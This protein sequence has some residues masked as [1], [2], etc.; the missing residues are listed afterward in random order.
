M[1][2][3]LVAYCSSS[4]R[5]LS[6]ISA[7]SHVVFSV[8]DVLKRLAGIGCAVVG[9]PSSKHVRCDFPRWSFCAQVRGS[10]CCRAIE[11]EECAWLAGGCVSVQCHMQHF[12]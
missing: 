9:M 7:A 2:F 4:Q 6:S 3:A 8:W 5:I 11:D 12:A 10:G 1:L